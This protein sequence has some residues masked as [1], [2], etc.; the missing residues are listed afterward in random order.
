[1]DS[2]F[3]AVLAIFSQLKSLL[4]SARFP[5]FSCRVV[6]RFAFGAFQ[7]DNNP[8]SHSPSCWNFPLR[9]SVDLAGTNFNTLISLQLRVNLQPSQNPPGICH[10]FGLSATSR[11][12]GR[13]CEVSVS[14]LAKQRMWSSPHFVV[15]SVASVCPH[16]LV[17]SCPVPAWKVNLLM[18]LS[19]RFAYLLE[20]RFGRNLAFTFRQTH[21]VGREMRRSKILAKLVGAGRTRANCL[22]LY[23]CE[24]SC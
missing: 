12:S 13:G 7:L 9:V 10:R 24:C 23:I 1:M 17:P 18:S 20:L 5:L 6:S 22:A 2:M 3:A 16:S 21:A 4:R 19:Y 11:R 8:H 14:F 15:C